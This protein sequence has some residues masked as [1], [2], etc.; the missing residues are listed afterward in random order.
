MITKYKLY[1]IALLLFISCFSLHAQ[2]Q[3]SQ[4]DKGNTAVNIKN[5]W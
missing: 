3:L 1:S 5:L 2:N 4:S